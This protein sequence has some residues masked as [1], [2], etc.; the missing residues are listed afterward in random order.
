MDRIEEASSLIIELNL[1]FSKE[2]TDYDFV[3]K[4]CD[5]FDKVKGLDLTSSDLKFLKYISNIAGVPHYY[6]LL[7]SKFS[8]ADNFEHYDLNTMSAMVYEST[9]HVDENIKIHKF[10][11]QVLEL[12]QH[13]TLNR[14]FL[15]ATTSFGKTFLI[16]E[17]IKKLNYKNIV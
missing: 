13:D 6:D 5:Y 15:S 2:I 16:Y 9:L 11:K 10:Q 7:V 4:V 14:I 3:K 1:F 17:I 8:Q 12:F